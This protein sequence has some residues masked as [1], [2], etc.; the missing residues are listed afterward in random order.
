[1]RIFEVELQILHLGFPGTMG[2][3]WPENPEQWGRAHCAVEAG[4][5]GFQGGW[6]ETLWKEPWNEGD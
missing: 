5:V 2:Q 3:C 6:M 1:M 4:T